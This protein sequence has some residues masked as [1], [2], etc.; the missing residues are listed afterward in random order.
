M[1][2][3]ATDVIVPVP[4]PGAEVVGLLVAGRRFDDRIVR[5][6]DVPF[7]EV[8]AAAAGQAVTRLRLLE[9]EAAGRSEAPRAV[10]CPVCRCVAETGGA[11]RCACGAPYA[12]AT[13]RGFSRASSD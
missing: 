13:D 12:E 7:L 11:P 8:L 3:T 5:P 1:A 2:E 9:G 4:G 10:E 6:V